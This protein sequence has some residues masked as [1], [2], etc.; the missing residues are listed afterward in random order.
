MIYYIILAPLLKMI[1]EDGQVK[2][3]ILAAP[4]YKGMF[5]ELPMN[6][7]S[8]V[9]FQ[10]LGEINKK[11]YDKHLNIFMEIM[12]TEDSS[13]KHNVESLLEGALWNS[14]IVSKSRENLLSVIQDENYEEFLILQSLYE[15]FKLSYKIY[16]HKNDIL[17]LN[18][19]IDL[20]YIK[21]SNREV[22]LYEKNKKYYPILSQELDGIIRVK[23]IVF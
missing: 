17:K 6:P 8:I 21:G 13:G 7:F 19:E 5:T 2:L 1:S 18:R 16:S 10:Y 11:L 15:F 20:E 22:Y 4:Y 12:F 14:M 3:E 9:L 23:S